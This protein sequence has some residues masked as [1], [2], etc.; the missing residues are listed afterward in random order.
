VVQNHVFYCIH[1][2]PYQYVWL[3]VVGVRESDISGEDR[4]PQLNE[5]ISQCVGV[6]LPGRKVSLRHCMANMW[7]KSLVLGD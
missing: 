4:Q 3:A 5:R 1:V 6:R 7:S 2:Q